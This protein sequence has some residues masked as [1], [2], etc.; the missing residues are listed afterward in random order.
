LKCHNFE[1]KDIQHLTIYVVGNRENLIDAWSAVQGVF[2][3]GVPPATL[4]GVVLLGYE[5]Q[6]VELD[7]KIVK[8]GV[9]K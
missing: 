6:L 9:P 8:D 2:V 3:D 4:L 5:N 1:K 7:A